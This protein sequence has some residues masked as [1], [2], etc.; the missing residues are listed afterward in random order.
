MAFFL[1]KGSNC[2]TQNDHDDD[3]YLKWK[4]CIRS[5]FQPII[6]YAVEWANNFCNL[7]T[8][9]CEETDMLKESTYSRNQP[10]N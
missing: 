2:V 4:Y 6:S 1:Y 5:G 9:N 10:I 7:S 8:Y 3:D